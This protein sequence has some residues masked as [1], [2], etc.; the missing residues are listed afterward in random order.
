MKEHPILFSGPMI[1]AILDGRKTQT[2]RVVKPQPLEYMPVT[3]TGR[4]YVLKPVRDLGSDVRC[5][6]H[7]GQNLWVRETFY[8]FDGQ[9]GKD[10]V[11]KADTDDGY[12]SPCESLTGGYPDYC[13]SGCESCVA[14]RWKP[15]WKPSIH[16]PRWASRITMEAVNVRVERL[17]DISEED[18]LAEGFDVVGWTPTFNNPDNVN[19]DESSPP[20]TV[21]MHYWDT[22]NAKRGYGWDVN[23]WVWVIEFTGRCDHGLFLR[24]PLPE[25]RLPQTRTRHAPSVTAPAWSAGVMKAASPCPVPRRLGP[26]PWQP[27]CFKKK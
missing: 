21:F 15:K 17:R 18:A 16:M 19:G 2:R 3:D 6:Y 4:Q 11:Y 26:K 7:K 25:M 27:L 24:R 5:P 9:N 10:T 23:P 8:P 20:S 1:Q 12:F 13:R 22:L 14:D